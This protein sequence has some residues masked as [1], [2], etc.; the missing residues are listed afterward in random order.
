[1]RTL[2]PALLSAL[3]LPH[4]AAASDLWSLIVSRNSET[5]SLYIMARAD[6]FLEAAAQ[7]GRDIRPDLDAPITFS[8]GHDRAGHAMAA[9][10]AQMSFVAGQAEYPATTLPTLLHAGK[11]PLPFETPFQASISTAVCSTPTAMIAPIDQLR[12][13]AGLRADI[14]LN[15][16][17]VTLR[18]PSSGF[19]G[20]EVSVQVFER[21]TLIESF[22]ATISPG[23]T[24]PL[25]LTEPPNARKATLVFVALAL[26]L[27]GAGGLIS[28]QR[29]RHR[30]TVPMP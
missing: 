29:S 30:Q 20:T 25:S 6:A 13:Y 12:L 26:L 24:L 2:A 14:G 8:E 28:A 9:L 7:S 27:A 10:A 11:S 22:D 5:M 16:S 17:D 23:G 18:W 3:L 4:A 1:M 21:G 15:R 19:T